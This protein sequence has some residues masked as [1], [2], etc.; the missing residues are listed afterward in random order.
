M[1]FQKGKNPKT[2][3]Q[4]N[5]NKNTTNEQKKKKKNP[6]KKFMFNLLDQSSKQYVWKDS[7]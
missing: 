1:C 7:F 6:T 5:K 3:K 2:N 4:T